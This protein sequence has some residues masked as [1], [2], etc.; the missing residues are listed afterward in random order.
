[1]HG[2]QFD[3]DYTEEDD[4]RHIGKPTWFDY[5]LD[6]GIAALFI[7]IIFILIG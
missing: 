1:M 7:G 2:K 5:V 6:L 4:L 3:F